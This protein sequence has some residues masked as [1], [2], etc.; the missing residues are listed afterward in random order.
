L[1]EQEDWVSERYL[2]H[3]TMRGYKQMRNYQEYCSRLGYKQ[4]N[5]EEVKN[6]QK[7]HELLI[8]KYGKDFK[9][10][11]GWEWIPYEIIKDRTLRGLARYSKVDHFIPF[12]DL[13]SNEIHGGPK[14]F[15]HMGLPE[16]H[17]NRILL[18]GPS[19][20]GMAD[21]LHSTAISL[22]RATTYLINQTP[23]LSNIIEMKV[24]MK[25]VDKV[26]ES[27]LTVHQNLE[28]KQK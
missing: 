24:I 14:G 25:I 10:Q 15:Y 11:S 27:S 12:Y 22:Q 16:H 20:F 1:S 9:Y 13:A 7:K 3:E 6:M 21:S 17:R 26:G 28:A 5:D 4:Y 2:K 8:E 23:T 19:T 18:T